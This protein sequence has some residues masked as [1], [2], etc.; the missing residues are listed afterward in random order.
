MMCSKSLVQNLE[1]N[2]K[3]ISRLKDENRTMVIQMWKNDYEKSLG[4]AYLSLDTIV[5]LFR[6]VNEKSIGL[7]G[8]EEEVY[9]KHNT[10]YGLLQCAKKYQL[11]IPEVVWDVVCSNCACSGCEKHCSGYSC[12]V[13]KETYG[14]G[15]ETVCDE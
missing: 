5:L 1:I 13:C 8:F 2:N 14:Q 7:C 9:N 4:R 10:M 3:E 12:D 6:F 11:N 15:Y